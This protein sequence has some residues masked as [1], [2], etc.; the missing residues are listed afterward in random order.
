MISKFFLQEFNWKWSHW[1]W[2]KSWW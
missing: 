1:I 2:T